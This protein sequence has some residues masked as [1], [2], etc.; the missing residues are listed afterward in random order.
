MAY[1]PRGYYTT[2]RTLPVARAGRQ[3]TAEGDRFTVTC[4][5]C[6]KWHEHPPEE[7]ER[8]SPCFRGKYVV[9]EVREKDL[10]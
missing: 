7:G 10:D 5:Y 3:Y 4:P 2:K 6:G 9:R 8:Y 1:Y